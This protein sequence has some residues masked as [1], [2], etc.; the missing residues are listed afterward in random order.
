MPAAHAFQTKICSNTENLPFLASA[1]MGFFQ[2]HDIAYFIVPS[3]IHVSVPF[4][5]SLLAQQPFVLPQDL[6]DGRQ[7]FFGKSKAIECRHVVL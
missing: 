4:V 6:F 1:G 3:L 7:L 5:L 2:F